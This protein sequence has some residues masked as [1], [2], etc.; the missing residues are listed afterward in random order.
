MFG[1]PRTQEKVRVAIVGGGVSGLTAAFRCAQQGYAPTL[2]EAGARLGGSLWTERDGHFLIEHGAQSFDAESGVVRALA[3]DLGLT[4]QIL[5]ANVSR[6]YG[7]DGRSLLVLDPG[8]SNSATPYSSSSLAQAAATFRLGMGQLIDALAN[9]IAARGKLH[10]RTPIRRLEPTPG[11]WRLVSACGTGT[12]FDAIIIA[13]D[14]HTASRLLSEI[15]GAPALALRSS[16]SVPIVSIS[17]AYPKCAIARPL[18]ATGFV[19]GFGV[20]LDDCMKCS[21]V[22]STFEGRAPE[23]SALLRVFLRPRDAELDAPLTIF[24]ERATR[25][26]T[27]VLAIDGA[28]TKAWEARFHEG[29]AVFDEAQLRRVSLVESALERMPIALSG[30]VFYGAGIDGAVRSADDAVV[31]LRALG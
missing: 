26:V 3:D 11:G 30:T 31:K 7:Y 1:V 29:F 17:L 16:R 14:A 23:G 10:L 2:F 21:F 18:D 20:E 12:E 27:R 6:S 28:P 13:S 8:T 19:T 9:E 5:R 25:A 24:R 22:S 15:F 4:S